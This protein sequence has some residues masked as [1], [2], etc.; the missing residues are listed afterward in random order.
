VSAPT[1]SIEER[2]AAAG[3]PPLPRMAWLELDLDA[4]AGN[5]A[6]LRALGGDVPVH[7]VVK[8][9]AYG[10]GA[11][12]IA[13]ALVSA[14]AEGLSVATMDEA[15][16]LREAGI[17][18]PIRVLYP[19]P[20]EL[21]PDAMLGGITIAVGDGSTIDALVAAATRHSDDGPLL[22]EIEVETGLG[23]GGTTPDALGALVER[24]DSAPVLRLTGVWTHLQAS[25]DAAIT[26]RQLARFDEAAHVMSPDGR[27][28]PTRHVAASGGLLTGVGAFD[29]VRPGLSIYGILPDELSDLS[30]H[31]RAPFRPVMSLHARPIRVADLPAGYGISYGPSFT[32][33]RPSR[34]A[35]LPLGYGDGFARAHANRAEALVRGRRVPLVGNVTMDAVMADVT[36]V[37]GTP[38]TLADEFVLLGA[39]GDERIRAEDLA[40]QRTTNTWEV[41][42]LMSARL[43]RVYHAATGAVV[44]LRTLTGWRG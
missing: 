25:E 35:T 20:P 19:I 27:G 32:T 26:E 13:R 10:H 14:G 22:V 39:Q 12:P 34:I 40:Q 30:D 31:T 5:L 4:L 41:V 3:L 17:D 36:D 33:A 7:P 28:L 37:P 42:T 8:A 1:P 6:A 15:L 9:D 16:E 38:V 43:P 21:V 23:R 18:G 44:G 11:V 24:I 2:L 29:G